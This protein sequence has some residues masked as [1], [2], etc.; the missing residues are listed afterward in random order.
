MAKHVYLMV[1]CKTDGCET[2][3]MLR[4]YGLYEG[5]RELVKDG[6]DHFLYECAA[7]RQTHR[8]TLEE[9][10]MEL[11]DYPIPAARE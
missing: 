3:C 7:C 9:A 10:R 1:N 4:Y 2:P 5:Q 11:F 6:P 8:Y